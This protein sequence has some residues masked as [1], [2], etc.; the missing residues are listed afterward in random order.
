MDFYVVLARPGYNV[1]YRR[2]KKSRVGSPHR[3]KKADSMKWFQHK[4][5]LFSQVLFCHPAVQ[6]KCGLNQKYN[7]CAKTIERGSWLCETS[8]CIV[9]GHITE[10]SNLSQSIQTSNTDNI[11]ER[12]QV[13]LLNVFSF[14]FSMMES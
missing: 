4:V 9:L 3:I 5:S 14:L 2:R 6:L 11:L 10:S 13:E 12:D 1:A 8:K 7:L